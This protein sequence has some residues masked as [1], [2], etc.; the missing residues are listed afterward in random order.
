MTSSSGNSFRTRSASSMANASTALLT[1]ADALLSASFV[2]LNLSSPDFS[3]ANSNKARIDR[4]STKH[5]VETSQRALR[6]ASWA[7]AK[8]V[9]ACARRALAW[10]GGAMGSSAASAATR[11]F[12][13]PRLRHSSPETGRTVSPSSSE[14]SPPIFGAAF[15]AKALLPCS[16]ACKKNFEASFAA[17]TTSVSSTTSF[18][19]HLVNAVYN[20]FKSLSSARFSP[21]LWLM[22]CRPSPLAARN[23]S[24]QPFIFSSLAEPKKSTKTTASL[25]RPLNSC[26]ENARE[27]YS[28]FS[29]KLAHSNAPLTSFNLSRRSF[30]I[31][32][33]SFLR[34]AVLMAFWASS[35]SSSVDCPFFAFFLRSL[36]IFLCFLMSEICNFASSRIDWHCASR[37]ASKT[38]WRSCFE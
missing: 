21:T 4:N 36:T 19:R 33:R 25:S 17:P 23:N 10:V 7:F 24:L 31:S 30:L 18:D 3:D 34:A 38:S 13:A 35:T 22:P 1:M 37:Y 2:Y 28:S 5:S 6:S 16:A 14:S 12:N 11:A 20:T 32:S 27:P 15:S 8:Q 29:I 26:T 9:L